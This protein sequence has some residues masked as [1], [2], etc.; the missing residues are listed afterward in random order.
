MFFQTDFATEADQPRQPNQQLSSEKKR[1]THFFHS[2]P[3]GDCTKILFSFGGC[4]FSH[5]NQPSTWLWAM[6]SPTRQFDVLCLS[7]AITACDMG[8]RWRP[9]LQLLY[10]AAM[11]R[12][13]LIFSLWFLKLLSKQLIFLSMARIDK[14]LD[15]CCKVSYWLV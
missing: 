5:I 12:W 15:F 9:A 11:E 2:G 10:A 8:D 1:I 13:R 7:S 6:A 14:R 4:A 3:M